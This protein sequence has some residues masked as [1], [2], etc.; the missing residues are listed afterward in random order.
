MDLRRGALPAALLT[1][2]Q[3]QMEGRGTDKKGAESV[4]EECKEALKVKPADSTLAGQSQCP[5]AAAQQYDG[6]WI[7]M[8][9]FVRSASAVTM[10][11][12]STTTSTVSS[13]VSSSPV[14]RK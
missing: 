11:L 9:P 1:R 14:E 2:G 8:V 12:G 10:V 6:S 5:I 7:T 4:L 13:N 3:Y